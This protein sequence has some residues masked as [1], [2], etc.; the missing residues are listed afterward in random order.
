MICIIGVSLVLLSFNN[1]DFETNVTAII[2]CI[3]NTGPGFSLVGPMGNYSCFN[4]FGKILLSCLMLIGRLEIYPILLLFM[5][6][7]WFNK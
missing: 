7:V 4:D 6:K 2:A 1:L 5:P 3:N